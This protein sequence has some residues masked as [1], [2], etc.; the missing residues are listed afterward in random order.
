MFFL[1][2]FLFREEESERKEADLRREMEERE[3]HYRETVERLQ[4]QVR[5]ALSVLHGCMSAEPAIS[6]WLLS[7]TV[8]LR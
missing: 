7:H 3:K 2:V 5:G 1:F 6:V 8:Y 4:M